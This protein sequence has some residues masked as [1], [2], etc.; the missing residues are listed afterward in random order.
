MKKLRVAEMSLCQWSVVCFFTWERSSPG[1]DCD[2][3]DCC[4]IILFGIKKQ[5]VII[6]LFCVF[7]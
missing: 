2:A 5:I 6:L 1:Y 4:H 3:G 7:D